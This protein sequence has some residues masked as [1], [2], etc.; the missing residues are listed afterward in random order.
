MSNIITSG[1]TNN[2]SKYKNPEHL[3]VEEM[4]Q[5]NEVINNNPHN[6]TPADIYLYSRGYKPEQVIAHIK[7]V[8]EQRAKMTEQE[9][10]SNIYDNIK[11]EEQ[12]LYED[13]LKQLGIYSVNPFDISF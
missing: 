1:N 11:S 8:A 4:I 7:D 6:P 10:F 2:T 3:T 12:R 9:R 5:L 13:K